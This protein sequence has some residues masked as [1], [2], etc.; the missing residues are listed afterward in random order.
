MPLRYKGAEGAFFALLQAFSSAVSPKFGMFRHQ[1]LFIFIYK[2][3]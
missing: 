2:E 3:K 1:K